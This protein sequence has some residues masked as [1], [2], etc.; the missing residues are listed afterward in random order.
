[1]RLGNLGKPLLT[2]VL[3]ALS[4]PAWAG[5]FFSQLGTLNPQANPAVDVISISGSVRGAAYY[6]VVGSPA[7][8]ATVF[9]VGAAQIDVASTTSV[10]LF[11]PGS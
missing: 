1:M 8:G 2:L 9:A 4:T 5:P 6:N 11:Q 10:A 7:V 3:A